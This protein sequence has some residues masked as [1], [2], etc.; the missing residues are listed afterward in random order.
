MDARRIELAK[1]LKAVRQQ[2]SEVAEECGRQPSEITLIG[3]TK[4]FPASDA[5]ILSELGLLDLGENR[6][7]EA[8]RKYQEAEALR[9][10]KI[11]WHFVGQL[12]RNK[13]RTLLSFADVIHS[14]DRSSLIKDLSSEVQRSGQSPILLIQINLD[15]DDGDR[16]GV[17]PSDLIRLADEIVE[18]GLR[19][20]GVMAVAPIKSSPE[21]AFAE[22][23]RLHNL[24]LG[25]HPGAKWRSA[26]MSGDFGAAIKFGATHLRLGSSILG[27]RH[28]LQ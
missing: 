12:Q 7:Q 9:S 4:N 18:R 25:Q 23:A 26:G 6:V 5:V 3:I 13:V 1:N 19:L 24:L 11:T 14:V 10:E 27:S 20:G 16:G 8:E 22:L 2:I 15:P 28:L 21:R 17:N